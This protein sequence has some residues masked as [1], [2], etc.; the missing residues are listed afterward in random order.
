[1]VGGVPSK[2]GEVDTEVIEA[3]VGSNFAKVAPEV[4]VLVVVFANNKYK[5]RANSNSNSELF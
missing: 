2:I 1:M 4:D 3:I 5:Q